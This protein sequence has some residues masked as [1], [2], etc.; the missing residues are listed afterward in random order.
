MTLFM[1][2]ITVIW[3]LPKK[4][5]YEVFFDRLQQEKQYNRKTPKLFIFLTKK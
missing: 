1:I 3:M 4:T 5:A 2:M